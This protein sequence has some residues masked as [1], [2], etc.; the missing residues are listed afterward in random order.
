MTD[1]SGRCFVSYRRKRSQEARLLVL[2]LHDIGVPTWQD[3]TDL[4][5]EPTEDELRRVLD[6]PSTA[7]ALLWIT[8]EVVDSPMVRKIEIPKVI[9]RRRAGDGFFAQP[10]AAGGL[11]YDDAGAMASE[12]LG[13]DD[14]AGWNLEKT[15]ADPIEAADAAHVAELLLRRR[16]KEIAAR[17]GP[18]EAVRIA[19]YTRCNAPFASGT[20]LALDW[21]ETVRWPGR[22]R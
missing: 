10:V 9:E 14:L 6:D 12:H 5:A 3:I 1:P 22:Y 18:N 4:D 16:I 19:L 20:A 15:D 17:L 13:V 7:S 21:C 11:D 2:A 8:P